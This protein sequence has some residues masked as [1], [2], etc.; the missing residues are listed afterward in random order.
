MAQRELTY[1]RT[2]IYEVEARVRFRFQA[3]ASKDAAVQRERIRS[4]IERL[5]IFVVRKLGIE[6]EVG[7]WGDPVQVGEERTP[8][9]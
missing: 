4:Y 1:V 9:V 6:I 8:L 5:G 2:P 7:D 3:G